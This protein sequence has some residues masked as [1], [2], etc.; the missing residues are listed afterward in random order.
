MYLDTKHEPDCVGEFFAPH[1]HQV[2]APTGFLIF[3]YVAIECVHLTSFLRLCNLW[4]CQ[5]FQRKLPTFAEPHSRAG[6]LARGSCVT[7]G[8]E[9]PFLTWM[10]KWWHL[11]NTVRFCED[12]AKS[13]LKCAMSCRFVSFL[14][15]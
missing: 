1:P 2:L 10:L 3:F 13:Y 9:N 11:R 12:S 5:L 14:P 7:F 6:G 8:Y 15:C 4:I